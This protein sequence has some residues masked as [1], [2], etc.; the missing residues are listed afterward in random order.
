MRHPAR[1]LPTLL[2]SAAATLL[3]QPVLA[4]DPPATPSPRDHQAAA[5][6]AALELQTEQLAAQIK[7]GN[8][9]QRQLLLDRLRAGTA[10]IGDSYL[11]SKLTETQARELVER[12][13]EAQ[14][15]LPAA[16]LTARQ[17]ACASTGSKLD[18]DSNGV[19]RVVVD[20]LAKKRMDK[21]LRV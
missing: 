10:F 5:C 19:Q 17:N 21:L 3:A 7:A 8:D 12:A 2:F 6:V 18:G 16:E 9:G 20:R 13:Q 14:K 4:A 15:S 11:H 1:H